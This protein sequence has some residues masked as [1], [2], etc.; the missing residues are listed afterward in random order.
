MADEQTPKYAIPVDAQ[1]A[2]AD[3]AVR[4]GQDASVGGNVPAKLFLP[5]DMPEDEMVA[6]FTDWLAAQGIDDDDANPQAEPVDDADAA[7]A[8]KEDR[9][10]P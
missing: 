8:A 7:S 4:T 5:G 1:R 3:P 9:C 2:A 6:V 10:A